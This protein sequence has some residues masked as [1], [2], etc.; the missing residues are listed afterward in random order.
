MTA[1]LPPGRLSAS[2][3]FL[4]SCLSLQMNNRGKKVK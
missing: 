1:C 2:G 3:R 4:V